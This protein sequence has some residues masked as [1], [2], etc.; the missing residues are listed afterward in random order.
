MPALR[1]NGINLEINNTKTFGK[2]NCIWGKP[3]IY[4]DYTIY[5]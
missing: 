5:F 4:G 3:K 1:H 2:D